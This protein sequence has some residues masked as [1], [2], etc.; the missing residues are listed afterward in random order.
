MASLNF[1]ANP[2]LNQLYIANNRIYKWD[3]NSWVNQ[4]GSQGETGF[5]GSQGFTITSLTETPTTS[6]SLVEYSIPSGVTRIT[7]L[8]NAISTLST[9]G[10]ILRL[11][12]AS[13]TVTSGYNSITAAINGSVTASTSFTSAL[14]AHTF[15]NAASTIT[16][17]ISVYRFSSGS[18]KWVYSGMLIRSGSETIANF[19]SGSV[20]LGAELTKV[21]YATQSGTTFDAGSINILYE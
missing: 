5:T 16:G 3:G 2:L 10:S 11:A 4:T 19:V 15:A 13:G 17:S 7:V 14:Y 6:G 8:F 20:D 18:N 21:V 12:T 1:P 9:A